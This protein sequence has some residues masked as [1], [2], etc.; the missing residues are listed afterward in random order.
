[1]YEVEILNLKNNVKFTKKFNNRD[2]MRNFVRKVNYSNKLRLLMIVD[3]SYLYDQVC[4]IKDDIKTVKFTV[5]ISEE[6]YDFYNDIAKK[7]KTGAEELMTFILVDTYK[8][9][10]KKNKKKYRIQVII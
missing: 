2:K 10:K 7:M 4:F 9:H 8:R 1:M 5:A 6:I 3:N